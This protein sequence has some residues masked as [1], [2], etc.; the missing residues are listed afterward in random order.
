MKLNKKD[1]LLITGILLIIL[2]SFFIINQTSSSGNYVTIEQNGKIIEQ[3]S[4]ER[5]TTIDIRDY[6][7]KIINTLS[8][9]DKKVGMAYADC[10]DQICVK[11]KKIS[12]NNES[13]ICLPNK[14][15]ITVVS[16]NHEIDGVAS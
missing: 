5:N 10:P 9:E 15:I 3:L 16:N 2:L 8:I 6:S 13:I 1:I 7:G 14:V 12:K 11:H 4:L